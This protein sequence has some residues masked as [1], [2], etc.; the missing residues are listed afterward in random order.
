MATYKQPCIHCNALVD[1]DAKFCQS[2]GSNGPFGYICPNCLR[3]IKKGERICP[4]CGRSTYTKCP[5]CSDETFR[6]EKCEKCGKNLMQV[7]PNKRC[8][9]KQFFEVEK[10]TACGKKIPKK[11]LG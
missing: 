5:H 8:G 1:R 6:Q 7:C 4:G 11:K 9:V 10:C 3:Q 2:C